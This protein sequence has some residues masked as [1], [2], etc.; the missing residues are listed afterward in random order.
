[1]LGY[2]I[3]AGRYEVVGIDDPG[4]NADLF[5]YSVV[6][7]SKPPSDTND[8]YFRGNCPGNMG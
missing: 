5:S 6:Q 8:F 1:M 7:V 3:T 2:P 4:E